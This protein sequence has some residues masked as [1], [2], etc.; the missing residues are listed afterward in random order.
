[1]PYITVRY[2]LIIFA[3]LL[4]GGCS[5]LE[6]IA[7]WNLDLSIPYN[8]IKDWAA[9]HL[10]NNGVWGYLLILAT[11]I[12]I[13]YSSDFSRPTV[14]LVV[15]GAIRAISALIFIGIGAT[16]FKFVFFI[17]K[18]LMTQVQRILKSLF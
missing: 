15:S 11:F 7:A 17:C 10:E 3:P 5:V 8:H 12:V 2:F 14:S 9:Y 6:D 13:G 4:F 16:I 1:M 18:I